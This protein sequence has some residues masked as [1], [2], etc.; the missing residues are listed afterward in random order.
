MDINATILVQACNFG[1]TYLFLRK[2]LLKP[3]VGGISQK[4]KRLAVLVGSIRH[5]ENKTSGLQDEKKRQLDAFRLT[6]KQ[7]YLFPSFQQ[8]KGND[9]D[10]KLELGFDAIIKDKLI[11]ESKALLVTRVPHAF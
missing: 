4:K 1:I 11:S 9:G 8:V 2:F 7:R 10:L 6:L 3:V 5:R